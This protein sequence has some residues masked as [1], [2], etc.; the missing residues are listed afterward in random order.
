MTLFFL[1]GIPMSAAAKKVAKDLG[2][3]RK[4]LYQTAMQVHAP[5]VW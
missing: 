2:V 5:C 1:T 3:S 4:E